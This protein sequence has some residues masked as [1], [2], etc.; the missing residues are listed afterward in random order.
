MRGIFHISILTLLALSLGSCHEVDGCIHSQADNYNPE[1]TR[2]DGSCLYT[3]IVGLKSKPETIEP[4]NNTFSVSV[5]VQSA[6]PLAYV[7]CTATL[8]SFSSSPYFTDTI[9]NTENLTVADFIVTLPDEAMFGKH[10]VRVGCIDNK[11]NAAKD[12]FSFEL[13]DDSDPKIV[14]RIDIDTVPFVQLWQPKAF[15]IAAEWSDNYTLDSANVSVWRVNHVNGLEEAI[16]DSLYVRKYNNVVPMDMIDIIG[17]ASDSTGE[18]GRAS[19]VIQVTDAKGHKVKFQTAPF[20]AR[21]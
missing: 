14:A 19:I 13:K 17:P 3:P 20:E 10:T 6:L 11:A 18:E 2:N 16:N 1:A 21:W 9:K 7:Y 4:I 5:N 12:A 8:K 15:R